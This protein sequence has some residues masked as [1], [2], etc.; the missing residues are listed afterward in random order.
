MPEIAGREEI[1]GNANNSGQIAAAPES[2]YAG[3]QIKT[4][5]LVAAAY[6]L[7]YVVLNIITGGRFLT[8]P[9]MLAVLTSSIVPTFIVLGFCF[10]F[11]M[12]IMDLS[13]GAILILASNVG[14]ILAI[15]FGLGYFGLVAG[16]VALAVLLELLNLKLMLGMAMVY[17]AVGSFYNSY[18]IDQGLQ[19][20]SLDNACRELGSM[21]VNA[22]VVAVGLIAAYMIY[23]R[24]SVGFNLRAV[25]SNTAVAKMMGINVS[26]TIMLAG[27]IG[28]VFIG[29][30][31]AVNES[32][33]GRIVPTTGLN[34]ISMIFIPLAA[35]LLAKAFEKV[36]NIIVGAL[37]SAFVITSIFNV[38]TLL[39]VPSGTLQQVVMGATVLVCGVLSQRKFKGVVQ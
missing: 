18:Q 13:M 35:F 23:N 11:T 28:G 21:P 24:T 7:I 25:G 20:V 17:E 5:L 2:R 34:S 36:F 14:G 15:Q 12:G 8:A 30:A 38:L 32:Y 33:A 16:A 6:V 31:S 10:I 27:I 9:N 3:R 4:T 26:K 19:V 1:M 29:L 39:G 37:I 22:I